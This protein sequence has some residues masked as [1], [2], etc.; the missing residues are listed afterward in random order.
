MHMNE[1]ANG[2]VVDKDCHENIP[3]RNPRGSL[4][5]LF[6]INVRY[7]LLRTSLVLS[8]EQSEKF[9]HVEI[10]GDRPHAECM[11]SV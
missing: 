11:M 5:A 2:S 1:V 8:Q 7:V 6:N 10:V 9:Y 4:V 3:L